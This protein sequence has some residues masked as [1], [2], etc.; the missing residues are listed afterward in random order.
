LALELEP[1]S[2]HVRTTWCRVHPRCAFDIKI[3][4]N[5]VITLLTYARKCGFGVD[6]IDDERCL[7]DEFHE[8]YAFLDPAPIL[9]QHIQKH[10]LVRV[11]WLSMEPH[12]WLVHS[13]RVSIE[14]TIGHRRLGPEVFLRP[15]T[16]DPVP[17]QPLPFKE[18][19]RQLKSLRRSGAILWHPFGERAPAMPLILSNWDV[20]RLLWK[21]R[22][23]NEILFDIW[24]YMMYN[25]RL[26]ARLLRE[27]GRLVSTILANPDSRPAKELD[28]VFPDVFC[29]LYMGSLHTYIALEDLHTVAAL[30][31]GRSCQEVRTLLEV[32]WE[33]YRSSRSVVRSLVAAATPHLAVATALELMSRT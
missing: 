6:D 13:P 11:A 14:N 33:A 10:G 9:V 29:D 23:R 24:H 31:L 3:S 28:M 30:L 21:L 18:A 32:Q 7:D 19:I 25:L 22:Y 20:A 16:S 27:I 8:R 5:G 26:R 17:E 4:V 15:D 1:E 12:G 2:V